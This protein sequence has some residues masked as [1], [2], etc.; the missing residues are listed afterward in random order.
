M[1]LPEMAW[2]TDLIDLA[3]NKEKWWPFVNMVMKLHVPSNA[4]NYLTG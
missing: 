2:D 3:Q 1:Y 4:Q